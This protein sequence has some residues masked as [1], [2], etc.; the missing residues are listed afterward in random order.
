MSKLGIYTGSTVND[1]TG[2]NLI[3]GAIK[4]NSN[5]DEIYGAIGDGTNLNLSGFVTSITAGSNISV[6]GPTGNVTISATSGAASTS[7]ISADTLVVSGVST[8]SGATNFN[9]SISV[10]NITPTVD[11]NW[12]LGTTTFRWGTVYSD[13]FIGDGVT[14][15][16]NVQ[17]G[18]ITLGTYNSGAQ[19]IADQLIS[20]ISAPG[21]G[22]QINKGVYNTRVDDDSGVEQNA[23]NIS[24]FNDLNSMQ[25]G[26]RGTITTKGGIIG[27]G[28]S[29]TGIATCTGG[30]QVGA[31][32]SFGANGPTAV[33]YGDG[34]NLTGTVGSR[35]VVSATTGSVS[36][37]A[38]TNLDV[39]G[40][41]SYGLLKVG[42]SSAAWV[43]L[44]VDE[45]SRT[46]DAA[47]SYLVDPTPGSGLI[48]EVRTVTAGI[49][50]FLM[51]PGVIGYN[52][53]VSVGSTIYTS[54]TNN[55]STSATI[56]V[57]LTVVKLEN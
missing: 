32:Q 19:V 35:S 31:G 5:F 40:F 54:V 39:S 9:D 3:D 22:A 43:R 11:S 33:Y 30:V 15:T 16:G 1:G 10:R 14:V 20:G 44:Y 55:E 42:I 26:G 2:D 18:N 45:S 6:S 50:T 27:V 12:S 48:A 53:D 25:I 57:D 38:T 36:V 13:Q 21:T 37:G 51:T 28:L 49:S 34:S 29:I 23:F 4:I 8:F 46:S 47:R 24:N 7:N 56:T 52:N 17:A 41:K